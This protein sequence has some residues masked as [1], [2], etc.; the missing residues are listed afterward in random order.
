MKKRDLITGMIFLALT[1]VVFIETMKLQI[2]TPSQPQVG[3]FPLVLAILL[4]ILTLIFLGK[5]IRSRDEGKAPPWVSGGGLRPLILTTGVLFLYAF[6]FEPL[7]YLITTLL[8]IGFLVGTFRTKKWW[9]VVTVALIS[10]GVSYL[11]FDTLLRTT[12]PKGLLEDI[13]R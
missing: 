7:G 6:F 5:T 4:G 8:L 13:L 1:I 10:T 3:F 9:V 12:L 2:G 11:L